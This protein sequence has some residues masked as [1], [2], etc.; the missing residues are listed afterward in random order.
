VKR[1]KQ[2]AEEKKKRTTEQTEATEVTDFD[3]EGDARVSSIPR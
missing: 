2:T 3:F 1:I